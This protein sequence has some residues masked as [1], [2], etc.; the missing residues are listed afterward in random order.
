M[1]IGIDID[2]TTTKTKE[3]YDKYRNKYFKEHNINEFSK[4]ALI[5]F[6][7]LYGQNIYENIKYKKNAIKYINKLYNEGHEIYFVTARSTKYFKD[8]INATKKSFI[9]NN[10]LFN[11][12]IFDAKDKNKASYD[13]KL[14]IFIDDREK[15]LDSF[16]NG[17]LDIYLILIRSFKTQK[18]NY[19]LAN[20]WKEIY[21]LIKNY[22]RKNYG[23]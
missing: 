10:V 20:N 6:L 5:D 19:D 17:N 3:I 14:D 18:S 7:N 12:I 23:G 22:E 1:K 2:D 11:D 8:M 4:E 13:L 16:Y 15:V 9:K 21:K